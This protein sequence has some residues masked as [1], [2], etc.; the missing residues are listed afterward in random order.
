M[1]LRSMQGICTKPRAG[2]QVSPK[3]C[4]IPISAAFSICANEPPNTAV[5]AAAAMEQATPT[6]P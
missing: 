2:S 6:S 3:K 5:R 1:A 4:S